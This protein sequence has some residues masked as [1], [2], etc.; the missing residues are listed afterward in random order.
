VENLAEP[1]TNK[2]MHPDQRRPHGSTGILPDTWEWAS[3]WTGTIFYWEDAQQVDAMAQAGFSIGNPKLAQRD[4]FTQASI[5]LNKAA[6]NTRRLQTVVGMNDL[7]E[8]TQHTLSQPQL[9][10][11]SGGAERT[12]TPA[13][14]YPGRAMGSWSKNTVSNRVQPTVATHSASTMLPSPAR[15]PTHFTALSP[16]T[17]PTHKALLLTCLPWLNRPPTADMLMKEFARGS[18][19]M[20][21]RTFAAPNAQSRSVY[22]H[23]CDTVTPHAVCTLQ[24]HV[25]SHRRG[26]ICVVM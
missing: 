18:R 23:V 8:P 10:K 22:A 11:S 26:R 3:H 14:I 13:G 6:Q 21:C 25:F 17:T 9:T 1:E 20:R 5:F 19:L 24:G 2:M 16:H 15:T 12:H 4:T 7:I